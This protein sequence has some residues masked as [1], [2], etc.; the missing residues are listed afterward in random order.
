MSSADHA[1]VLL[2]LWIILNKL[3]SNYDIEQEKIHSQHFVFLTSLKVKYLAKRRIRRRRGILSVYTNHIRF[4]SSVIAAIV[5]EPQVQESK[6]LITYYLNMSFGQRRFTHKVSLCIEVLFF[7]QR[8]FHNRVLTHEAKTEVLINYWDKLLWKIGIR[9]KQMF[10]K[11]TLRL[12][13]C[14]IK[15]PKCVQRA[16]LKH[17]VLKCLELHSIAF[18][19]WRYMFCKEEEKA[20][21]GELISH[22][23]HFMHHLKVAVQKVSIQTQYESELTFDFNQKYRA[24]VQG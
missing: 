3:R 1:K 24:V 17:F 16:V 6:K 19:Q 15:V 22:R 9:A 18:F 11:V 8:R 4:C 21:I 10:D 7:I 23:I 5:T 12:V 13:N 2:H 14:I 20:E